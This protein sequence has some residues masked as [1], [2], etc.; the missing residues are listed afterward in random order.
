MLEKSFGCRPHPPRFFKGGVC[1]LHF[2]KPNIKHW[3]EYTYEF[4]L[5]VYNFNL[6]DFVSPNSYYTVD[7]SCGHLGGDELGFA[8]F[9]KNKEPLALFLHGGPVAINETYY[10]YCKFRGI[11]WAHVFL[12]VEFNVG[13]WRGSGLQS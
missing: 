13:V 2:A 6:S 8:V 11:L 10:F 3:G 1:P 12:P 9:Q 4:D 5:Y 7:Q